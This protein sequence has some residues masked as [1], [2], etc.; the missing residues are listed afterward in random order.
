MRSMRF[1]ALAILALGALVVGCS[2]GNHSANTEAPIFLSVDIPAGPADVNMICSPD[3]T[4]SSMS[5]KSQPKAPGATLSPQDDVT[6]SEFVVTPTRT[7]GGTVASPQWRN[8]YNISIPE[9]GTASLNNYR[10]FPA[11]F[12]QQPPLNQ[13]LPPNT[14][15]D[16]ETGST[17][18]RQMLHVEIFG[19]TVGGDAVSVAF[20]V[21]LRFYAA[22]PCGA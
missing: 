13:L 16:R 1:S 2:G 19:K 12:F 5:I 7:D 4:I 11:D 8:Y 18:I 17:N 9:G 6:L 15:F 20:D 14:G 10:I 3:V 22:T 21:T